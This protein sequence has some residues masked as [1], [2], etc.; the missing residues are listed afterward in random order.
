MEGWR[1]GG[2][3]GR[4]RGRSLVWGGGRG[5]DLF[6]FTKVQTIGVGHAIERSCNSL[7]RAPCRLGR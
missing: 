4:V 3:E 6:I 7:Y 1:G 2:E 5:G